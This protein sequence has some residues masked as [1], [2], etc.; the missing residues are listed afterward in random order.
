[1]VKLSLLLL[2]TSNFWT[3]SGSCPLC[4]TPPC[5]H[6]E[7]PA[8]AALF[9][10]PRRRGPRRRQSAGCWA[11]VRKRPLRPIVPFWRRPEAGNHI[12]TFSSPPL[13]RPQASRSYCVLVGRACG[14][15]REMVRQ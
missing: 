7:P 12:F 14:D 9:F 3:P 8:T 11:L 13:D 6:F 4:L 5:Y 2:A 1:M 10:G 15:G